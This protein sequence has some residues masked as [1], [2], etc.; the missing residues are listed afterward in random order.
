MTS[1][2]KRLNILSC[3]RVLRN[4]PAVIIMGTAT[5]LPAVPTVAADKPA[6]RAAAMVQK[7][8]AAEVVGGAVSRDGQLAKVI[9]LE[10]DYAPARWAAGYVEQ[11]EKWVKFDSVINDDQNGTLTDYRRLRDATPDN[12]DGQLKLANWCHQHGLKEQERAHLLRAL[13][14]DPNNAELRQRLGMVQIGGVWMQ[15]REARR[16]AARG[17]QALVDLKHWLPKVEKFRTALGGPAGRLRDLAAEHVRGIRDPSA[18]V[19]LETVLAPSSDEAGL[20]AVDALAAMKRPDAAIALARLATFSDSSEIT[21]AAQAKLKTLPLDYFVPAMLSSLVAPGAPVSRIAS[22]RYGRLLFQQAFVYEGADRKQVVVFDSVYRTTNGS[23]A[24]LAASELG[25][26]TTALRTAAVDARNRQFE[27]TNNRIIETLRAVTGQALSAEPSAWWTWWN[28]ANEIAVVG[29]KQTEV[30]FIVEETTVRTPRPFHHSCLIAGTPI[31]TDRG[32]VAVDKM[33]VGDRVLARDPGS[34][35]LAYKPVLRTTVRPRS[36]LIHILLPD[37][38]VVA[39]GGHPF[40]VVGQG[41]VNARHLEPEMRIYT[42]T[43][44]APVRSIEIEEQGGQPV[45][46]LVV[47]DFHNYFAGNSHLL[48]H[49]ITPREPALGPVP[50]WKD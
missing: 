4:L 7:T 1:R 18:I 22:D 11:G 13:D 46:N 24:I 16:A 41:W 28:E 9:E 42:I 29:D 25:S 37:E 35:E 40:W 50:G 15:P 12:A 43:G 19:A 39:S 20:A 10:P 30:T 6:P 36:A 45:Y 17:K 14:F 32:P 31:W 44:T 34:G 49:D 38:K 33:H 27:R 5:L 26:A 2:E 21:D 23:D 47:E 8:L 3:S 48:L